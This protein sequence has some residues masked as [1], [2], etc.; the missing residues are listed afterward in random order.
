[1]LYKLMIILSLGLGLGAAALLQRRRGLSGEIILM[2]LALNVLLI[3]HCSLY[4]TYALSKG[5]ALGLN[6]SGGAFG[7]ILGIFIFSLIKPD[8]RN[9]FL[10]S[11]ICVLP[12]MY[13]LGKI[14]CSFAGCCFGMEYHGTRFPIQQLEA[15]VFITAFAVSLIL[16][17]K[18]RF[19]PLQAGITYSILKI[20]LDFLRDSH[21][22][23]IISTNQILCLAIILICLAIDL[24]FRRH[25]PQKGSGT[26]TKKEEPA[27]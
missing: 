27:E 26:P 9:I 12:L 21:T 15:I 4:T 10:E 11:Y 19:A 1:M 14:G 2:S 23:H 7:M 18:D 5:T 8:Y 17:L 3:F 13:G 16:V 22:G 20:L 24:Y 6:A 25:H